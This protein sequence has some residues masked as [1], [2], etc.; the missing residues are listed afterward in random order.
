MPIAATPPQRTYMG[1]VLRRQ[2]PKC[3]CETFTQTVGAINYK[4]IKRKFIEMFFETFFR[5]HIETIK[6][7][8]IVAS[9]KEKLRIYTNHFKVQSARGGMA[10]RKNIPPVFPKIREKKA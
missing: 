5:E 7:S 4:A 3:G 9:V 6:H 8:V 2:A 1:E 10:T